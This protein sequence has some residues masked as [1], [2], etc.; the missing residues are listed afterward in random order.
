MGTYITN[1][2][3]KDLKLLINSLTGFE[4]S[5]KIYVYV[6]RLGSCEFIYDTKVDRY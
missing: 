3:Y 5:L 1:D 2:I 4:V 6:W